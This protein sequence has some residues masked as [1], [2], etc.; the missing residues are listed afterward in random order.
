MTHNNYK[1]TKNNE[2]LKWEL[3]YPS[4]LSDLNK[5][6]ENYYEKTNVDEIIY[7]ILN[8]FHSKKSCKTIEDLIDQFELKSYARINSIR[9]SYLIDESIRID[10]D[11]T[12]FNYK[13]GEIELILG[14]EEKN[15]EE[16][17][18]KISNLTLRLG[19]TNFDRIPG[20]ISTYL[21]LFN[22]KLFQ[23]LRENSIINEKVVLNLNYL[24]KK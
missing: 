18:D 12:D 16:S 15:I 17:I 4:K 3:K 23:L 9:K 14:E 5:N 11:E 6:V 7:L 8:L 20:K 19:I 24:F 13:I 10:L 21:Y 2:T 22:P 1:L